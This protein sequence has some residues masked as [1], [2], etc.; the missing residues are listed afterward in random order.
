MPN[1]E[2]RSGRYPPIDSGA[3]LKADSIGDR[4]RDGDLV[5]PRDCRDHGMPCFKSHGCFTAVIE[6]ER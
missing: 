2:Q 1:V 6:A 3:I 5:F 4:C